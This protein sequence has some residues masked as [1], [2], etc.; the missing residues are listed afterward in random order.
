VN[1]LNWQIVM[2]AAALI[3]ERNASRTSA[4][5]AAIQTLAPEREQDQNFREFI[6]RQY[7]KLSAG[8]NPARSQLL[9]VPPDLLAIARAKLPKQ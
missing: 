2:L 6:D 5:L 4:L 1:P 8:H 3:D 7:T 9:P